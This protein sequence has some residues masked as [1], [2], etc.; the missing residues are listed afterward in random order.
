MVWEDR[1]PGGWAVQEGSVSVWITFKTNVEKVT[2]KINHSMEGLRKT[3][4]KLTSG[5]R[6]LVAGLLGVMFAGMKM[7]QMFG[8]LW[9]Q[10]RK[11]GTEAAFNVIQMS[12]LTATLTSPAFK[13]FNRFLWEA[14]RWFLRLPQPVREAL[15]GF[16]IFLGFLGEAISTG[17]S[18]ALFI[19]GLDTLGV[20][21]TTLAA[22]GGPIALLIAGLVG[23]K[24]YFD[25]FGPSIKQFGE[26]TWAALV[27]FK[28]TK[29]DPFWDGVKTKVSDIWSDIKTLVVSKW[30]GVWSALVS[31]MPDWV[32]RLFGIST[33]GAGG[34][35]VSG[36]GGGPAP[37]VTPTT[38]TVTSLQDWKDTLSSMDKISG[39]RSIF[40]LL[41]QGMITSEMYKSLSDWWVGLKGWQMGGRIPKTGP[42]ILHKGEE[43]IPS[44]KARGGGG[45]ITYSPNISISGR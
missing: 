27:L 1:P 33:G 30:E 38:R 4:E 31:I 43:V 16:Q 39:G 11:F 15:G 2:K 10:L 37:T 20:S 44:Y 28:A 32:K 36:A 34:G 18:L 12:L 17:G 21:L 25:T 9:K 5:N 29:W 41:K 22:V 45:A 40:N 35:G 23:L 42:Y 6:K 19:I 3:T 7:K 26:D 24:L 13:T 8:G 14:T